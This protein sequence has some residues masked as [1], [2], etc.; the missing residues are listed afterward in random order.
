[1]SVFTSTIN[2]VRKRLSRTRP[3][4]VTMAQA[5]EEI[6]TFLLSAKCSRQLQ[7]LLS[8]SLPDG[9]EPVADRFRLLTDLARGSLS[10]E[11]TASLRGKVFRRVQGS[12]IA[13]GYTDGQE[14][15]FD[16]RLN[17]SLWNFIIYYGL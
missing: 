15:T 14:L 10:P 6:Q 9:D 12:M 5:H 11:I 7:A 2:G 17:P 8:V 13:I 4:T 16:A 3:P 1:M